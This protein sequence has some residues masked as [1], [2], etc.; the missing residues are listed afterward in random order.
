M[1]IRSIAELPLEGKRV[2][3]RVDFNVPLTKSGEVSDDSRIKAALP[4][5]EHAL[6]H[7]ARLV[8][9][10]HLGRPDGK[11]DPKYSLEPAGARLSE[12][13]DQDVVLADDCVG[14]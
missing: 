9:M 7:R 3:M 6:A 2:L 12:L 11:R 14:D 10:S 4:S 1:A 13:L 5:I 8:I